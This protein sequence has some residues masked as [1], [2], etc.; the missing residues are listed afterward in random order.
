MRKGG[1]VCWHTPREYKKLDGTGRK[2]MLYDR[3]LKGITL[4][5]EIR[6]VR[7]VKRTGS[8]RYFPWANYFAPGTLRVFRR[9]ISR[10]RIRAIADF[11]NFGKHRK[12]RSPYRNITREVYRQLAEGL[13]K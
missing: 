6:K 3:K 8:G 1:W 5:V 7:K 12:D 4:E 2:L 9:P 11:E 13:T 10:R